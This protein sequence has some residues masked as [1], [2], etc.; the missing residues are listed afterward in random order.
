MV[1]VMKPQRLLMATLLMVGCVDQ[2][3]MTES[4]N[5]AVLVK[6]KQESQD[7][8]KKEDSAPVKKGEITQASIEQVFELKTQGR[9]V[10]ID[11]RP[12]IFFA[13]GHIDG[14][15][16]FPLKEFTEIKGKLFARVKQVKSEGKTVIIY[17]ANV[18]CPDS[19]KMAVQLAEQ[20]YDV[21]VFK[22]GW[23][24]WKEAGLD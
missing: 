3:E 4:V 11:T 7:V 19:H 16:S 1:Q 14:A 21:S 20:G 12:S 2:A 15:E 24:L 8:P 18:K 22:E 17:C 9:A 6:A 10:L 5:E 23:E 13:L